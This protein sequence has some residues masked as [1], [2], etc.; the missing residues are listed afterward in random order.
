MIDILLPSLGCHSQ[1]K[2]DQQFAAPHGLRQW[3]GSGCNE[4]EKLCSRVR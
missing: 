1:G 4:G 3:S 2:K